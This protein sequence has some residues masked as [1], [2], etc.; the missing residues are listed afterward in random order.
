MESHRGDMKTAVIISVPVTAAP[1]YAWKWRSPDGKQHS[2]STFV[3]F[4]DCVQDARRAGFA[5]ELT[6]T[7]AKNV[8][9]STRN[10][11]A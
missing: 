7:S 9:E 3:Y 11:L 1:S 2:P 8:D 5:I 6:G 10:G 4:Y